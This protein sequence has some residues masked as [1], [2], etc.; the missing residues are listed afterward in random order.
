MGRIDIIKRDLYVVNG[1]GRA[2]GNIA[3]AYSVERSSRETENAISDLG[4]TLLREGF[5]GTK[6]IILFHPKN[7]GRRYSD[8]VEGDFYGTICSKMGSVGFRIV[9]DNVVRYKD[10]IPFIE[11]FPDILEDRN[12]AEHGWGKSSLIIE[13]SIEPIHHRLIDRLEGYNIKKIR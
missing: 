10:T 9:G 7:Y 6:S 12:G 2:I 8:H 13:N 3:S 5:L 11:K 1:A 4:S